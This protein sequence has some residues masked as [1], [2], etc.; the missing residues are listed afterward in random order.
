VKHQYDQKK[1][2]KKQEKLG[3]IGNADDSGCA[4]E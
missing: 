4:V 2:R 1:R 3:W